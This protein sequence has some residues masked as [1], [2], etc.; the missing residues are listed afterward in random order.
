MAFA[1]FRFGRFI[2]LTLL[3]FG[4]AGAGGGLWFYNEFV[5]GLPDLRRIEDY[6]PPV[7]SLVLDRKGRII[8]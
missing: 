3:L 1:R 4:L 6:R 2:L 5:S 8:G 7:T